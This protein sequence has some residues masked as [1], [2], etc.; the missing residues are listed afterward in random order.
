MKKNKGRVPK[1]ISELRRQDIIKMTGEGVP[2]KE[3]ARRLG[4]TPVSVCK[5]LRKLRE[6]MERV[7]GADYETYRV[8]HRKVLLLI[9]KSLLEGKLSVKIASEW[10]QIR[11]DIAVFDGLNAPAKSITANFNPGATLGVVQMDFGEPVE[12]TPDLI[13]DA[14]YLDEAER[15]TAIVK[16]GIKE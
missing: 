5:S 8:V 7:T 1:V 6:S 14:E 2:N 16:A 9:E 12:K 15:S 13:S 4:I 11:S 10:R 3:I